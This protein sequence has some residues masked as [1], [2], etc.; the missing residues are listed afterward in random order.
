MADDVR[1]GVE[2]LEVDLL[3]QLVA[4]DVDGPEPDDVRH[5]RGGAPP[6]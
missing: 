6:L 5:I 1:G 2:D 4:E 3:L